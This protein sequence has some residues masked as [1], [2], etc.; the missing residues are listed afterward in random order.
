MGFS[1]ILGILIVITL[2]AWIMGY[3]VL[4]KFVTRMETSWQRITHLLAH[5]ERSTNDFLMMLDQMGK[6]PAGTT[7]S[8]EKVME[9]M[10]DPSNERGEQLHSFAILNERLEDLFEQVEEDPDV[11]D[12]ELTETSQDLKTTLT[13]L[14]TASQSYNHAVTKYNK[15]ITAI[16]TKYVA[17]IHQFKPQNVLDETVKRLSSSDTAI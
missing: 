4:L 15:S 13:L 17:S 2:L 10:Q 16:P 5:V 6:L 9:E 1:I 14:E 11:K 8:M 12:P 7:E 3:Y